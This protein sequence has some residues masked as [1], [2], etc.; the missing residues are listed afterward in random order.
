MTRWSLE[1]KRVPLTPRGGLVGLLG[2]AGQTWRYGFH[3]HDEAGALAE[4][5]RWLRER[6]GAGGAGIAVA[7]PGARNE[8]KRKGG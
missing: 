6:T 2:P 3:A 1:L 8:K 5:R 4:A 7:G